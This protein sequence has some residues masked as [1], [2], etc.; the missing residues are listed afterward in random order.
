ME[1]SYF[2]YITGIA[3]LFGFIAQILGWFPK[4]ENT[5]RNIL[6]VLIGIFA[7]SL[8]GAFNAS[9]ITFEFSV[10]GF[11]LL[12]SAIGVVILVV[13]LVAIFSR[14]S[15]KRSE[16]YG[17]SGIATVVFMVVLM[18]GNFPNIENESVKIKNEKSRLTISELV[19][20]S[21][22]AVEQR[23]YDRAL[24]HLYTIRSRLSGAIDSRS[25]KINKKIEGVKNMQL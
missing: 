20:L 24:M 3:S 11:T 15:S 16:M 17:V 18:F 9:Q 8:F 2:T 1:L 7:G 25:E 4:Y 12:I 14:D 23:S 6:L 19:L 10:T 22:T 13:L 21:D 5:R